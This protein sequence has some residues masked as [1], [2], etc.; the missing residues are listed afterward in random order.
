MIDDNTE[1]LRILVVANDNFPSKPDTT[2]G[3]V[4]AHF[5][6]RYRELLQINR[7]KLSFTDRRRVK[8]ALATA[9]EAI[10]YFQ[11]KARD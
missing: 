5:S 7:R 9:L 2:Y 10:E 8:I 4:I 6:R 3:D 1:Q 11:A